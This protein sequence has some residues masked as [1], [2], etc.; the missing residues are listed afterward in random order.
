LK[1]I[2][3]EATKIHSLKE[4][5]GDEFVCYCDTEENGVVVLHFMVD[6]TLGEYNIAMT[7][8][9]RTVVYNYRNRME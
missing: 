4:I 1:N 3:I 2:G 7:E 5:T 8:N 6:P 9:E